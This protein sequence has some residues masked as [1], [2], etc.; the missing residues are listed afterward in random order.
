MVHL[1]KFYFMH[2]QQQKLTC[3]RMILNIGIFPKLTQSFFLFVFVCLLFGVLFVYC[4]FTEER[5][6]SVDPYGVYL[7]EGRT[8][9]P[10]QKL[11]H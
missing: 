8:L 2:S 6:P 1:Q 10:Q 7:H 3:W 5:F 4:I 11:G 9:Q